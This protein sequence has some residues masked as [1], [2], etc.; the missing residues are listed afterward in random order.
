[1][2]KSLNAFKAKRYEEFKETCGTGVGEAE[3]KSPQGETSAVTLLSSTK[4]SKIIQNQH[5]SN[6]PRKEKDKKHN[7]MG[8]KQSDPEIKTR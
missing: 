1:M 8:S 7:Q 2:D 6:Y 4:T 5:F 3:V